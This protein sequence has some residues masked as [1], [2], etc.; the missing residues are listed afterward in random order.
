M[1]GVIQQTIAKL[2]VTWIYI[3]IFNICIDK[4]KINVMDY[5]Y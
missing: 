1:A 3:Y 2:F 5:Y 4:V